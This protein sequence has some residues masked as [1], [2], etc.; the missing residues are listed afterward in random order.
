MN[1]S[2]S[3]INIGDKIKIDGEIYQDTYNHNFRFKNITSPSTTVSTGNTINY[4]TL[5]KE[6]WSKNDWDTAV[7]WGQRI[8][9]VKGTLKPIDGDNYNYEFT[10]TTSTGDATMLAYSKSIIDDANGGALTTTKDATLIGI[11]EKYKNQW[12]IKPRTKDD[13]EF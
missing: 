12:E 8:V 13:V 1:Y 11:L 4:F 3:G 9:K 2:I 6:L 10:Y 7:V 5:D